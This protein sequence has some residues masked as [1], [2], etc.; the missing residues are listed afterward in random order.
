MLGVCVVFLG[1]FY[2]T[3]GFASGMMLQLRRVG[4]AVDVAGVVA[5]ALARYD[6][7]AA[8]KAIEDGED[9]PVELRTPLEQIVRNLRAYRGY[10]PDLL[11][12]PETGKA[13]AD[14]PPPCLH[15][16]GEVDVGIVFT[17]IESSTAL[18][19]EYPKGMHEA[20]EIH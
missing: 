17:G 7:N 14:V 6:V 8:Q 1:D 3:N 15:G 11:L 12:H 18:W 2:F 10:L 9:L 13:E 19:A 16:D 4:A 20:L 5:A